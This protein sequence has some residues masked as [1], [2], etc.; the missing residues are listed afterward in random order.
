MDDA[1]S[2]RIALLVAVACVLQIAE[3]MIPHPMPGLRLGLAGMLTLI[4]LV[5]LG[6]G[7]A[8][9]IAILRT[10]LSSFI[11]GT[12]MSPTFMLSAGGAVVSTFAMALALRLSCRHRSFGLSVVGVSVVGAVTHNS[13]QLVL[14][15]LLLVRH[16][17][18]FAFYPWLVIGAVVVGWITGVIAGGVLRRLAA[19]D[20]V[21]GG[22]S[23][24]AEAPVL[25]HYEPGG[26]FVHRAPASVK[27]GAIVA[28]ALAVLVFDHPWLYVG[29]LLIV[30]ALAV[31]ARV[32][33]F[34]L[35][36]RVRPFAA[37]IAVA[38]LLPALVHDGTRVV[39]A[40]GPLRV[41][42]EGLVTGAIYAGRILVLMLAS[43]LVVRTTAPGDL[44]RGLATV[45]SPLRV[46]GIQGERVAAILSESWLAVPRFWGF[47]ADALRPSKLRE[48]R[49]VRGVASSLVDLVAALYVETGAT[50]FGETPRTDPQ[51]SEDAGTSRN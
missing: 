49:G 10:I 30:M 29:A 43:F 38:F 48:M 12:F 9:Q 15:Y 41:T 18:I 40:A 16:R 37:L 23:A 22:V 5:T 20:V 34:Y 33:P 17:A 39:L 3:S 45:L 21:A 2:H 19:G 6:F 1:K 46:V 36:S 7:Y 14:A 24:D 50:S 32:S 35:L 8:L 28:L 25:R 44:T 47:A 42:A 26:S 13:V 31:A 27:I 51:G 4:A 11:M